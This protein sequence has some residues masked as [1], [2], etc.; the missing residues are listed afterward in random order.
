MY[1]RVQELAWKKRSQEEYGRLSAFLLLHATGA[2]AKQR[3]LSVK[4]LPS[5]ASIISTFD[6]G[7]LLLNPCHRLTIL[8]QQFR[9]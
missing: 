7:L 5:S 3:I 2:A 9:L 8:V 4:P 6:L 1:A